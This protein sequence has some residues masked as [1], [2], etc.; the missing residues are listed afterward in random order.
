MDTVFFRN[1][2]P[3][4]T[5]GDS[6]TDLWP[7]SDQNSHVKGSGTYD[8][9]QGILYLWEC[10]ATTSATV[11]QPRS[12]GDMYRRVMES[13][14]QHSKHF[15]RVT[16]GVMM[17]Q[18]VAEARRVPV[19]AGGMII[20]NSR[21]MHQGWPNGPRLACPVSFE[22][23]ARRNGETLANKRGMILK[24]LPSTHW[25]SSCVVHSTCKVEAL[26]MPPTMALLHTAHKHAFDAATGVV[27]LEI[28]RLL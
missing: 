27:R 12:H 11:V 18:F 2:R 17:K 28:D 16:D 19:P 9:F 8:A 14:T 7:H 5:E 3:C 1:T 13:T 10:D 4:H 24:G 25:A 20:W 6:V 21:T 23:S 15:C 22:P 26:P